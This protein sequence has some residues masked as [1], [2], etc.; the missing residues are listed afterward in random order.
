[1]NRIGIKSDKDPLTVKQNNSLSK[2]VNVCIVCKLYD[3]P[4]HFTIN[5]NFKSCLFGA[6]FIVKNSDKEKY[7]YSGYGIT[8]DSAGS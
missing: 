5:F 8:F 6:I 7:V 3:W 1:M 4:K 2:I